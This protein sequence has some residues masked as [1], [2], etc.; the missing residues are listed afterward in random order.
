MRLAPFLS[1]CRSAFARAAASVRRSRSAKWWLSL[2]AAL[3][4]SAGLSFAPLVR[5]RVTREAERRGLTVDVGS[6]RPGW[7]AVELQDARV[8]LTGVEAVEADISRIDVKFGPLLGVQDV[9]ATGGTIKAKG[10]REEL[11][12]AIGAWRAARE[13]KASA[14]HRN[15]VIRA[16]GLALQWADPEAN[17]ILEA[18]GISLT[19]DE[20]GLRGEVVAIGVREGGVALGVG[21]ASAELDAA[22]HLR[23][24]KFASLDVSWDSPIS[25][26]APP[27]QPPATGEPPPPPAPILS[28]MRRRKP[29]G[30]VPASAP[31]TEPVTPLVIMPELHLL[32]AQAASVAELL[33]ERLPDGASIIVDGLSLRLRKGAERVSLGPGPFS[34]EHQGPRIKV[35]FSTNAAGNATPLSLRA[36]LPTDQGDVEV[37][38][39]G[40]PVSLSLLG[41]QEGGF[42]LT[43]VDRSTV[44]GKGR[45]VLEGHG[46]S[47]VFDAEFSIRGMSIQD[48]RLAPEAVRG[49]D[50]SLG[51][52]GVLTDKGELRLDDVEASMGALRLRLHGGLEQTQDHLSAAFDFD[53][54]VGGCQA[55]LE[56][57][58]TALLP[59]VRGAQMLGTLGGTGRIAFDTRKV[60]DLVLDYDLADR[61]RMIDVPDELAKD[62]FTKPF[63]HRIY[64]HDGRLSEE[65]TGPDTPNW[66]DL[67]HISPFMQAAVLTTEDGA[68]FHHRGFN[69]AAIR[70]AFIANLKAGRFLRGAST[71]TM[72]LAKNLFLTREKT[73][74]RKLEE[75]IL[76]DYLEQVFTK[77]EM[78]ELYLNI[79]EFGPDVYGVT[80]AA[81][82][83]FA[84]R[85]DELNFAESMFLSSILPRPVYYHK[86][87]ER[88]EV[89]DS[90][91]RSIRAWM[92]AA[93]RTGKVTDAELTEGLTEQVMFYKPNTPRPPPRPPVSTARHNDDATEWQELN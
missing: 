28:A 79:I 9:T 27:P 51:G 35:T 75:L 91:M 25:P 29:R 8:R 46:E 36:T 54:P 72:Q 60:D 52:R 63:V 40:G 77:E 6:V 84:R 89:G 66:T 88:G 82:H 20:G 39:A 13:P 10:S 32:R 5:G 76:T 18:S 53:L 21:K 1:A 70:N 68:F 61:C 19:R 47:L 69:H 87:Y 2:G 83:Y 45:V 22:L 86:L 50:L 92:E 55:L 7:F 78:M 3:A 42:G 90:W 23:N 14:G 17:M 26:A 12:V 24:A 62:R 41:V 74:S 65:T 4:L 16:E 30:A 81:D 57:I 56:S 43:D 34:V 33:T 59:T 37:S 58:P 44:A 48:A 38:L 11:R 64:T 80:E 49:L 67:D 31:N 71:I 15:L 85:P 93:R 73:L